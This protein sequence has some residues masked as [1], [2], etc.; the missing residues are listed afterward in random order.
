MNLEETGMGY[1]NEV[2]LVVEA[3]KLGL[4]TTP[5]VFNLDEAKQMAEVKADVIVAHMGLTTGGSI[6]AK[7]GKTLDDCV[8]LVQESEWNHFIPSDVRADTI[9]AD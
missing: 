4:L 7:T 5:Y 6:G 9:L 3:R 2:Q 8:K 1:D